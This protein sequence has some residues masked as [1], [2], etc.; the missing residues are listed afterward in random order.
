[1]VKQEFNGKTLDEALS[2]A[3]RAFGTDVHLLSYN[4]LPQSSGG[5]FSKLF[6]RGVRLEAWIDSS[7]DV[8]A[9]A[10]EA[11]RQAIAGTQSEQ[12]SKGPR[13][14]QGP[15]NAKD[16]D[17][18]NKNSNRKNP[19]SLRSKN[20]DGPS[21]GNNRPQHSGARAKGTPQDRPVRRVNENADTERIQRNRINLDSEQSKQL[22]SELAL[23]FVGGFDP[24]L[25]QGSVQI[26]FGS[27]EDVTVTVNSP[28]LEGFLMRTDK[29]SCAFEHLFKRIAQKRFGDVSGRVTLNAGNANSHRE[30][31]L[32]Q[33]ALDVASKVKENGKTITLSS[34]S[35]QER[36]VI[37]L[38]LENMEGI[39]TKSIGV[40][41]NRKLVIYSTTR[42]PRDKNNR[43]PDSHGQRPQS[44]RPR[45]PNFENQSAQEHTGFDADSNPDAVDDSG[46]RQQP[47]RNRRRGRRGGSKP[48]FRNEVGQSAQGPQ[49]TVSDTPHRT[50]H[51]N[52][53]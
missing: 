49:A 51:E 22:L 21:A 39:A 41:E 15:R 23:K 1:M 47:R 32:R 17:H 42:P 35:S 16:D 37:H 44:G 40:G 4:I 7:N 36:R 31:K 45:R 30:D 5:L 27:N 48:Q 34:K 10:R 20:S 38:E 11:V 43:R 12:P 33:L 46:T 24:D 9:A 6:Q 52:E 8:Q 18:R 50:N 2:A 3:A 25:E 19:Q 53:V 13:P 14:Q 26:E 28:T 29:L